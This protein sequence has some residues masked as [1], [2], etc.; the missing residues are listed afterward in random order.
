ML[1]TAMLTNIWCKDNKKIETYTVHLVQ[2]LYFVH[3]LFKRVIM[4][5]HLFTLPSLW[6]FRISPYGIPTQRYRG[7][8]EKRKNSVTLC[9]CV[10][11]ELR[12]YNYSWLSRLSISQ[13]RKSSKETPP[14]PTINASL[15]WNVSTKEGNPEFIPRR[16]LFTSIA[17]NSPSLSIAIVD[18]TQFS[19]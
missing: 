14:V 10:E 9:L 7:H 2:V 4:S 18:F 16:P 1:L 5:D 3:F 17:V 15:G 8:Q 11:I 19:L 12:H 13:L 6:N